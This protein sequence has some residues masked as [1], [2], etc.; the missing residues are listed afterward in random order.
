VTASLASKT[1]TCALL[2]SFNSVLS[3]AEPS[4]QGAATDE[5][6]AA[7]SGERQA[8]FGQF[9][10]LEEFLEREQISFRD[11][12]DICECVA[13]MVE[14][15]QQPYVSYSSDN[16]GQ[17]LIPLKTMSRSPRP[18]TRPRTRPRD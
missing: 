13:Q 16:S 4:F 18:S 9:D 14:D 15:W 7:N 2:P 10:V 8:N 1:P 11:K 12:S 3:R 17:P 6:S 5:D